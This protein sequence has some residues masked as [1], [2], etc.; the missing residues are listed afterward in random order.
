MSRAL[1]ACT[2]W[3]AHARTCPTEPGADPSSGSCT[4]WI[5]STTSTSGPISS[6]LARTWGR[7]PSADSQMSGTQRAEALGPEPDLLR[8]SSADT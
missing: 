7:T 3:C 4:A 8:D 6:T 1:A 5:E 2:S